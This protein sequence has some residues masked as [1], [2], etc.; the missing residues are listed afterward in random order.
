MGSFVEDFM[1]KQSSQLAAHECHC[2][3]QAFNDLD[4][5]KHI[6]DWHSGATGLAA[7]QVVLKCTKNQG[8]SRIIV[9]I[10]IRK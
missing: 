1:E 5:Q 8:L 10:F 3:V 2:G 6:N 9:E 4:L 7:T